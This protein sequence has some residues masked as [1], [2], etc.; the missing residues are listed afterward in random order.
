MQISIENIEKIFNITN[1]KL[2]QKINKEI[3]RLEKEID[4]IY[5]YKQT[6]ANLSNLFALSNDNEN[7]GC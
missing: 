6:M 5:E 3:T 1:D 4:Y 7:N 2:N